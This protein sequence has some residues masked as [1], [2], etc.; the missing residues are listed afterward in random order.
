MEPRAISLQA[1]LP[2]PDTASDSGRFGSADFDALIDLRQHLDELVEV[3]IER[4]QAG[5]RRAPTGKKLRKL[6][7]NIYAQRRLRDRIIGE[8]LFGEP[9]WDMLLALYIFPARGE[10]LTVSSLSYAAEVP[11]ATGIRW[12]KILTDQRLIE[13]GP[14]GVDARKKFLRLTPAGRTMMD[15]ILTRMLDS[16]STQRE[17]EP[18]AVFPP[19]R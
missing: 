18:R 1:K 16:E 15:R 10:M 14:D 2:I 17:R 7:S 12:Q 4:L 19:A 8:R 5:V 3:E 9:A 11:Q 6:A 13:R